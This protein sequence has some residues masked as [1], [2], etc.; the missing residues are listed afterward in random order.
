M[1]DKLAVKSA[2]IDSLASFTGNDIEI[3]TPTDM[4]TPPIDNVE[5][6]QMDL[7]HGPSSVVE[8]PMF[9]KISH[10]TVTFDF[11]DLNTIF[12]EGAHFVT[13]V[14]KVSDTEGLDVGVLTNAMTS[15]LTQS[16]EV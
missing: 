5:L 13:T 8:N 15:A 6:V 16:E 10:T 3:E 7:V 1:F 2:I 14:A 11:H 9:N 4:E 12:H